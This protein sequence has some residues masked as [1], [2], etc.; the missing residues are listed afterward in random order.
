MNPIRALG[1]LSPVQQTIAMVALLVLVAVVFHFAGLPG[2]GAIL[3]GT[4]ALAVT[5]P[6]IVDVE[7]IRDPNGSGSL[8]VVQALAQ[9]NSFIRSMHWKEGNLDTGHMVARQNALPSV[10]WVTINDGVTPSKDNNDSYTEGCGMLEGLSSLDEKLVALNGGAAYRAS[11]DN[12]FTSSMANTLESAFIYEST[13]ANPERILGLAP[14]LNSTSGKFGK[15]MVL[16]DAAASGSDQTSIWLIG[17]G[18]NTVYGI[19]PKGKGAGLRAT[20]KGNV[21]TESSGK[22][23]YKYETLFHWDCGLAVE[24]YRYVVRIANIDNSAMSATGTNLEI[25]LTKAYYQVYDPNGARLAWYGNRFVAAF[26]HM[27]AVQGGKSGLYSY[28]TDYAGKPVLT[29]LGIPFYVTDAILN[30]ESVLS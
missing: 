13:L 30:N 25:A 14:R 21:R 8:S 16:C 19:S 27:Q 17:W 9:K 2:Q 10:S 18:E 28:A 20:D 26:M 7:K 1:R 24:D 15:Q 4:T 22:V 3:L 6:T 23:T 12:A 29:V 11:L 5:N